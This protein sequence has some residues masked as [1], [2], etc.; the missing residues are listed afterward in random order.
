MSFDGDG[1][2]GGVGVS[3][4]F[5]RAKFLAHGRLRGLD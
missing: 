4:I 3:G 2:D 1:K 5:V